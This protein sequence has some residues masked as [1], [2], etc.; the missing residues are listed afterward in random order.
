MWGADGW[1]SSGATWSDVNATLPL[2]MK[3]LSE[4]PSGSNGCSVFWPCA[5]LGAS[6]HRAQ[7][8][9]FTEVVPSLNRTT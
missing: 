1:A 7:V 6:N 4:P 9:M 8:F 3:M 2:L 5:T